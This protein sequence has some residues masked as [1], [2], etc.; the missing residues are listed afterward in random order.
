[1]SD[2]FSS[3]SVFFCFYFSP[4][5]SVVIISCRASD[6]LWKKIANY[7]EI[8]EMHVLHGRISQ[9]RGKNS[10]LHEISIKHVLRQKKMT[11]CH[12][13][14]SHCKTKW[15]HTLRA[16]PFFPVPF[17]FLNDLISSAPFSLLRFSLALRALKL[18]RLHLSLLDIQQT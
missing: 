3:F 15:C 9:L 7:T 10:K 5:S 4:F 14:A 16:Y 12:I 6:R 13:L 11:I 17:R 18:V 1:M 2:F 8:W